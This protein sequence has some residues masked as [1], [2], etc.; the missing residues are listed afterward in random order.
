MTTTDCTVTTSTDG[1]RIIVRATT[2]TGR[3]VQLIATPDVALTLADSLARAAHNIIDEEDEYGS[4]E[5]RYVEAGPFRTMLTE[6]VAQV[7][8]EQ[9]LDYFEAAGRHD[10]RDNADR[11]LRRIVTGESARVA[12]DL[13]DAVCLQM[14][15]GAALLEEMY[16]LAEYHSLPQ[17]RWKRGKPKAPNPGPCS[18][19][20]CGRGPIRA[21]GLCSRCYRKHRKEAAA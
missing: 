11:A 9:V 16:P 2:A 5:R 12:I 7:G 19:P 1:D 10:N 4:G 8:K 15:G 3:D 6:L 13:V 18:V 20:G 21:L 17:H 14:D